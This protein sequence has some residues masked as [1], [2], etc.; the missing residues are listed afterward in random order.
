MPLLLKWLKLV[1]AP[2]VTVEVLLPREHLLQV[3]VLEVLHAVAAVVL[4]V[5]T[6]P[7]LRTEKE[8]FPL[9][10]PFKDKSFPQSL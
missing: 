6:D 4:L 3:L 8:I 9:F 2:A 1:C 10:S 7:L 5:L